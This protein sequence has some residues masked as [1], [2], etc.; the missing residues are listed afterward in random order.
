MTQ[1]TFLPENLLWPSSLSL[2]KVRGEERWVW[3]M[4]TGEGGLAGFPVGW[5]LGEVEV[6]VKS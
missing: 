4:Q 1:M 2:A 6:D 3:Y 5:F